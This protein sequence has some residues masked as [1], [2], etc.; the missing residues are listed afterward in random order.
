MRDLQQM[1]ASCPCEKTPEMEEVLHRLEKIYEDGAV[2]P[3]EHKELMDTLKKEFS[4]VIGRDGR[5]ININDLTLRC[6]TILLLNP[7]EPFGACAG[8]KE[9]QEYGP[10]PERLAQKVAAMKQN[11]VKENIA[12]ARTV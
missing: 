12:Y 7:Y 6:A 10:D 8:N 4:I 5:Y 3:N 9:C 2:T 11:P 1:I